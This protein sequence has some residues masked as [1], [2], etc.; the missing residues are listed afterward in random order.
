MKYQAMLTF[1][2]FHKMMRFTKLRFS[3][4]CYIDFKSK[5]KAKEKYVMFI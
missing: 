5:L 1:F 3:K 2:V 4:F